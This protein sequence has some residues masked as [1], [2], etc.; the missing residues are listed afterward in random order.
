MY[1][2]KFYLVRMIGFVPRE[3]CRRQGDGEV[4]TVI[5]CDTDMVPNEIP[6]NTLFLAKSNATLADFTELMT[7]FDDSF[8]DSSVP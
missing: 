2:D 1:F 8:E 7:I 5:L 4:K 6:A 3:F